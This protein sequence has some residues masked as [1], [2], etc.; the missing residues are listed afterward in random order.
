MENTTKIRHSRGVYETLDGESK[1]KPYFTVEMQTQGYEFRLHN[2]WR[3]SII[4]L[5]EFCVGKGVGFSYTLEQLMA[6]ID[7]VSEST[8]QT[9]KLENEHKVS[10]E[11]PK[12]LLPVLSVFLRTFLLCVPET[13]QSRF[14]EIYENL[15][16]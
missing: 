11:F 2:Y 16:K 5:N 6:M 9:V 4:K 14:E 13:P 10:I 12:K 7:S 8:T 15:T 1:S 3:L